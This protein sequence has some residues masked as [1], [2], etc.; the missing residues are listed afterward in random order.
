MEADHQ[1]VLKQVKKVYA[2]NLAIQEQGG[3]S[4][5]DSL[6]TELENRDTK[7]EKLRSSLMAM[8]DEPVEPGEDA[9]VQ[10]KAE[11]ELQHAQDSV[12]FKLFE[13]FLRY[14]FSKEQTLKY[15]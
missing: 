5:V 1:L 7:I 11:L 13:L 15:F 4:E 12:L 10:L 9:L 6:L 3:S 8:E 2:D 14:C